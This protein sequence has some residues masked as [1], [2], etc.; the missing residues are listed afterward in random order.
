MRQPA[1]AVSLAATLLLA[2]PALALDK[3]KA[4]VGQRG[5]WPTSIPEI[6]QKYGFFAKHGDRKSTRLNSSH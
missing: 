5:G 1:L 2:A 4:A 3:M 6:A